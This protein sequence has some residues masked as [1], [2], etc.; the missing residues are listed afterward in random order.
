MIKSILKKIL[1][2]ANQ[3][4]VDENCVIGKNVYIGENTRITKAK[5][6]N[7]CSIAPNVFIGQGEH[8]FHRISTST[9]F[10]DNPYD[11]LTKKS[12]EIGNDV[13]I[14]NNA[15]ILRGVKI[16]DG[17]VIGAG[18]IVTKNVEQFS[19]VVGVPAQHIKYRFDQDM[20]S[21][22]VQSKWW[23]YDLVEAKQKILE[24]SNEQ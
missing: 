14:G 10:I 7:Y 13:W 4:R 12:V 17:A 1:K 18:A 2:F 23:D 5:I 16:G 6:G 19:I 24:I 3:A 22:I 8:N 11:E 20:I 9:L 15:V 21:K